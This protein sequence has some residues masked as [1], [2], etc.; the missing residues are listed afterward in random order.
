MSGLNNAGYVVP[1]G[2]MQFPFFNGKGRFRIRLATALSAR[3]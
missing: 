1:A 3:G 2:A